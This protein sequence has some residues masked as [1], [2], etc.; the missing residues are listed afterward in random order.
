MNGGGESFKKQG[1]RPHQYQQR[2]RRK[3]QKLATTEIR[4]I[5]TTTPDPLLLSL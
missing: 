2:R 3:T 5:E 4:L 1:A